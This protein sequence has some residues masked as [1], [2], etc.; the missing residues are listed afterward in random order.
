MLALWDGGVFKC[1]SAKRQPFGEA[2][3]KIQ[4]KTS[5]FQRLFLPF[6]GSIQPGG[7]R[8]P[9][10]SLFL[11]TYLIF[12]WM[13]PNSLNMRADDSESVT[14]SPELGDYV[15]KSFLAIFTWMPPG[16]SKSPHPM[17]SSSSVPTPLV[18]PS[19]RK[20]SVLTQSHRPEE[21]WNPTGPYSL[22]SPGPGDLNHPPPNH[23]KCIPFTLTPLA[24]TPSSLWGHHFSLF[25]GPLF[26]G[27]LNDLSRILLQALQW[28][29]VVP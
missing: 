10:L 24:Q 23:T 20:A 25:L 11:S 16:P 22:H 5:V 27:S 26:R 4:E 12:F 19:W 3:Y 13:I 21:L 1:F 18:L 7:L 6:Y 8:L 17:P 14:H 29:Q 15:S 9:Y 2:L 28:L